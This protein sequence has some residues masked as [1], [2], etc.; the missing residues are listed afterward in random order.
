MRAF[1]QPD[2]FVSEVKER[3][4]KSGYL[5]IGDEAFFRKRC[6]EAVLQLPDSRR[7][8]ASS[9]SMTSIWRKRKS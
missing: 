4:L 7:I 2:R 5:F 3:K 1:A 9:R 8:C 6:R